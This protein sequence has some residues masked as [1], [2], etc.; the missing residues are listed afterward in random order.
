MKKIKKN[1]LID[2]LDKLLMQANGKEITLDEVVCQLSGKGLPILLILLSI[3]L[4]LPITIPGLSTPFGLLIV[5]IGYRIALNHPIRWPSKWLQHKIPYQML[6][7]ITDKIFWCAAKIQP[8]VY[9]R[10][11]FLT[12]KPLLHRLHGLFI[13][14][15]GILLALPLP[16]PFTNTFAALPI[17]LMSLA[18]LEDDGG[19]VIA[20]YIMGLVGLCYFAAILWLGHLG[21]SRLAG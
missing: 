18:L 15:M 10:L 12:K 16:L 17:L 14:F 8:L 7:N 9:T 4:A 6:V 1:A 21:I 19:C 2:A 13:C 20:A 11:S 3:P 5:F